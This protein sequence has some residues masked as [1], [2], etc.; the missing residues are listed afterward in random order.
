MKLKIIFLIFLLTNIKFIIAQTS[1]DSLQL[2][3][4]F[5]LSDTI[6]DFSINSKGNNILTVGFDNQ[7]IV[8]NI[9]K[10]CEI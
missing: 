4:P 10:K 1:S 9:E 2:V 8:W 5:G 3:L 7:I 6:N